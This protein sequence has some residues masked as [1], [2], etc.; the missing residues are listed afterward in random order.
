MAS[1]I[2]V[3]S[4]LMIVFSEYVRHWGSAPARSRSEGAS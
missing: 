1:M 4:V 3:A 2:M